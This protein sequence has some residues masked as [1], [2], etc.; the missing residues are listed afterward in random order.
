MKS[1]II[2]DQYVTAKDWAKKNGY[3]VKARGFVK[4][5]ETITYVD[6]AAQIMACER[7][8]KMYLHTTWKYRQDSNRLFSLIMSKELDIEAI[9]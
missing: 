3:E 8:M 9:S 6:N 2:A 1:F 5:E 7:E 4:G